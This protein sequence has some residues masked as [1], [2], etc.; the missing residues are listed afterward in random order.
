MAIFNSYFDINRGYLL[1]HFLDRGLRRWPIHLHQR[2]RSVETWEIHGD[3]R[4]KTENVSIFADPEDL[5]C[6]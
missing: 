6:G 4:G 1:M 5:P 2:L 3:P